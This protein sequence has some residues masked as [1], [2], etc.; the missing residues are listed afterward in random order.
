MIGKT[1]VGKSSLYNTIFGTH[2]DTALG[3]C[4]LEVKPIFETKTRIFWDVPGDHHFYD[5]LSEKPI[6]HF[7]CGDSIYI[8][9]D[10]T[11]EDVSPLMRLVNVL[12]KNL[13]LVRTKCD[14]HSKKDKYT[15]A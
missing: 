6:Q 12:N 1:S 7:A 13:F 15:L 5:Y 2:V 11:V 3:R 8:L 4:T 10:N 9:Y 14:L